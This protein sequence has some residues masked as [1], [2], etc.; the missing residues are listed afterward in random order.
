MPR[1]PTPKPDPAANVDHSP[2]NDPT[3]ALQ[4][5]PEPPAAPVD[6][7]PS[8]PPQVDL[9]PPAVPEQ[10]L[11]PTRYQ[12]T[13]FNKL[14]LR[15]NPGTSA[16]EILLMPYGAVVT[17]VDEGVEADGEYWLQVATT[18]GVIG[19]AMAKYLAKLN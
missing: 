2:T 10:D 6:T 17:G 8:E 11:S 16:P 12:V 19:Y 1:K 9:D 14:R 4:T 13:A 18:S 15:P 5:P 3:P 7:Q